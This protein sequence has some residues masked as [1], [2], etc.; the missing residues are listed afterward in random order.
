MS[1]VVFLNTSTRPSSSGET[2]LKLRTRPPFGGENVPAVQFGPHER[3]TANDDA[4]AFN[5]ETVGVVALFETADVDAGN[6]LQGFGYR[7]VGQRADVFRRDDID[8]G[9]GIAL[10]VLGVFERRAVTADDDDI[11]FI[12][13]VFR[14]WRCFGL[15]QDGTFGFLRRRSSAEGHAD[16]E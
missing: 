15:R 10:D 1:A 14:S 2:S 4:G 9:V 12:Q 16:R 11:A 7:P 13:R 3:Q 5:G 8:K 6:A